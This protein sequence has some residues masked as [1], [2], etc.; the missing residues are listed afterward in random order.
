[1]PVEQSALYEDEAAALALLKGLSQL[2]L[3]S[4]L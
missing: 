2:P 1:M 3:Y 4:L